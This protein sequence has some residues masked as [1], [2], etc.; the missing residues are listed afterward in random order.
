MVDKFNVTWQ[1]LKSNAG[2]QG[3]TLFATETLDEVLLCLA[4]IRAQFFL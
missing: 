1:L 3:P 2:L 4:I